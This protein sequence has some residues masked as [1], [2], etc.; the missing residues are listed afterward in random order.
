MKNTKTTQGEKQ[1]HILR[2]GRSDGILNRREFLLTV[3]F[4]L[5]HLIGTASSAGKNLSDS[6][7]ILKGNSKSVSILT[8][9]F[10]GDIEERID[11]PASWEINVMKMAGHGATKMSSD[12]IL[13][14][15]R[16]PVGTRA[17]RELA[18]G[19]KTV[20]ITFD[21]L[22]RPTPIAEVAPLVV[23]ELESAG[24]AK[25]GIFFIGSV[26]AHRTLEGEE[27][28]KKLGSR[29]ARE[30]KWFNHNIF[31]NLQDVGETSY[32]NRVLIN[33]MFMGADL[34]ITIS[35]VK[36]HSIA[37]YGGGSKAVLPGVAA[38]TT[39]QMNHCKIASNNKSVGEA[40]IFRND[41]KLDM[42]EAARLAKVDFSVQIVCNERREICRLVA[43]DV[44]DAHVAACREA[45]KLHRTPTLSNADIVIVNAYPQVSQG[46]KA[47]AWIN[48]SVRDDGTA[49]LILQ[50]PDGL[51]GYHYLYPPTMKGGDPLAILTPSSSRKQR[52]QMVV[53]SQYLQKREMSSFPAG[54]K[55]AHTWEDVI[56]ILQSRHKGDSRVAV[57]PYGT[58]QHAETDLDG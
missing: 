53:Y 35:G 30:Y 29:I 14:R 12:Q 45:N 51:M 32:K 56:S 6:V 17:L 26:G 15:L 54:T 48:R 41:V 16:N 58:L 24:V 9:E 40:R 44:I 33:E 21:D 2:Q 55:F 3:G 20:V 11:L 22:T 7:S 23:S 43:G 37:G 46:T 25:E 38:L 13:E 10:R 50:H 18:A 39:I 52:F 19:K 27:V 28:A 31:T 4:G 42:N 8:H 1:Q 57:Y 36:V 34:R 5:P 49:V 47:Q